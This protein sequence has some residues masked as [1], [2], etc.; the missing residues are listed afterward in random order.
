MNPEM[1][2]VLQAL[3]S[4]QENNPQPVMNQSTV[5]APMQVN[6][7]MPQMPLPQNNLAK[8]PAASPSQKLMKT[9]VDASGNFDGDTKGVASE[10]LRRL[11]YSL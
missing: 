7:G 5:A 11:T 4:R 9:L 3:Q 2:A 8:K 1:A 6:P 10:L